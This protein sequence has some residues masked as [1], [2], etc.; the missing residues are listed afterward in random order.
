MQRVVCK[1]RFPPAICSFFLPACKKGGH[2]SDL[3]LNKSQYLLF[4][5]LDEKENDTNN[6]SRILETRNSPQ[7]D[8][9]DDHIEVEGPVDFTIKSEMCSSPGPGDR[10]TPTPDFTEMAAFFAA[11]RSSVGN[12][13]G[14]QQASYNYIKTNHQ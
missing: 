13:Q 7:Q 4:F 14:Q 2:K 11:V 9:E 10:P 1:L 5:V 12:G 6:L 8:D 3:A